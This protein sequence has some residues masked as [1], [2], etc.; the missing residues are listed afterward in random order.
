MLAAIGQQIFKLSLIRKERI[1]LLDRKIKLQGQ[2]VD[3]TEKK[4]REKGWCEHTQ[5]QPVQG[6]INK[7]LILTN[8]KINLRQNKPG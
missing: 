6:Y 7:L 2:H 4:V 3:R 8:T 5:L 1:N